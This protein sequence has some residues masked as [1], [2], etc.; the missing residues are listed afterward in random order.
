MKSHNIIIYLIIPLALISTLS[1][2]DNVGAQTNSTT[3]NNQ[4]TTIT[5]QS[6]QQLQNQNANLTAQALQKTNIVKLKDTL[7]NIKLAIVNGNTKLALEDVMNVKTQLVQLEPSPPTKFLNNIHRAISAIA[8]SDIDKSLNI[9]TNIE[10]SVL[11]AENLIFKAA[12]TNPQLIQQVKDSVGN[13]QQQIHQVTTE[14]QLDTEKQ[15]DPVEQYDNA[16]FNTN[17]VDFNGIEDK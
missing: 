14:K 8:Q 1:L 3:A 4:T 13:P 15:Y 12:V 11:K 17:L 5:S 7:T 16:G 10:V 9:L 2:V 6:Q